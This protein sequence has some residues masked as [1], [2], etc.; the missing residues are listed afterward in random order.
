MEENIMEC[1]VAFVQKV[2][3]GKW[4]LVLI[5]ILSKNTM[6]FS[7][8][9]RTLPDITEA[10]LTKELR[11]L[12]EKQ[13]VSREIYKQVPPKVEYSLTPI[14]M[15]FRKVLDELESWGKEYLE[16]INTNTSDL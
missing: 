1:N 7:E 10:T 16:Y 2:I 13:I 9:K 15:K 6:R 11:S 8:I 4:S 3:S 14:G 5:Y 12:E